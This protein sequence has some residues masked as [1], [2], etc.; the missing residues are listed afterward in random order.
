MIKLRNFL[1]VKH[2]SKMMRAITLVATAAMLS[3][4]VVA[5]SAQA[6]TTRPM[7]NIYADT[8]KVSEGPD[9][10]VQFRLEAI[11]PVDSDTSVYV[12]IQE[13][14]DYI[15]WHDMGSLSAYERVVIMEGQTTAYLNLPVH[16]DKTVEEN[17]VV[18]AYVQHGLEWSP[19]YKQW[20]GWSVD[21]D[22]SFAAVLVEDDDGKAEAHPTVSIHAGRYNG[23]KTDCSEISTS[24]TSITEGWNAHFTIVVD[25]PPA[26]SSSDY[27]LIEADVSQDG[28]YVYTPSWYSHISNE[29]EQAIYVPS[30]RS[31]SHACM[32]DSRTI[33]K[34]TVP[35]K[36]TDTETDGSIT[37][38]LKAIG[39]TE[40]GQYTSSAHYE[41]GTP[42]MATVAVQNAG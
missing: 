17:G 37:V 15:A 7:V 23:S 25:N 6:D 11:E 28:D 27:L 33:L 32:D 29:G 18:R 36:A 16:D 3:V 38:M 9:A 12:L 5:A 2:R 21:S 22:H 42:D 39:S 4:T 8:W 30:Y 1:Q 20:Q 24:K 14:G 34:Y 31:Y 13:R 40:Y 41:I 26:A 10:V 19:Q 35:T